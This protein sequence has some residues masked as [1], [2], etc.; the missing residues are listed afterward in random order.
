MHKF[1]VVLFSMVLLFA[2]CTISEPSK[3]VQ[4]FSLTGATVEERQSEPSQKGITVA[5]EE[6]DVPNI[7]QGTPIVWRDQHHLQRFQFKHWA[8]PPADM[9]RQQFIRQLRA[10]SGDVIGWISDSAVGHAGAQF[11]VLGEVDEVFMSKTSDGTQWKGVVRIE[12]RLVQ[13]A[14]PNTSN[15]SF[16]SLENWRNIGRWILLAEGTAK[17]ADHDGET[18]STMQPLLDELLHSFNKN[19]R[20]IAKEMRNTIR[21]RLED[22]N[23]QSPK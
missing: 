4:Y 13:T 1:H 12:L 16:R 23:R 14:A 6:F 22:Q 21:E 10:N 18:I 20:T 15:S 5:V 17:A 19:S 2:G 7:Y 3:P 9:L 11:A 8:N